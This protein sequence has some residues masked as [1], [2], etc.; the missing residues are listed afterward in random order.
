MSKSQ[1]EKLGLYDVELKISRC[2][3]CVDDIASYSIGLRVGKATKTFKCHAFDLRKWLLPTR[4]SFELASPATHEL[5]INHDVGDSDLHKATSICWQER[6]AWHISRESDSMMNPGLLWGSRVENYTG[7]SE[8]CITWPGS[9]LQL[10][11]SGPVI[12]NAQYHA[13]LI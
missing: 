13:F 5:V 8:G 12:R 6:Q 2:V 3:E 10:S 4:K 1:V 11:C 7:G 9:G